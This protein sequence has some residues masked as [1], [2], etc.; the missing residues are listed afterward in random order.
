MMCR[1]YSR[2][3]DKAINSESQNDSGWENRTSGNTQSPWFSSIAQ[4]L[5]FQSLD[6]NISVD[7]VIVGGGIAGISTGY[8][9]SKAGK[10][11]AVIEDGNIGSG[12]T[13]RTTAHITN[14]LDDR[15]YDIERIHVKDGSRIA[16]ES[17]STAI[18]FIESTVKEENIDC[19]FV[20]LDGYLFLDPS[21][22]QKSLED[23]LQATQ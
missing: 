3:H 2:M 1:Y 14:A 13:G 7:V 17:H 19:D 10:K 21:E 9:L 22:K 5:K 16:A 6:R 18:D 23:E 8:L 4:K 12:E 15:Y 11:I 20:R